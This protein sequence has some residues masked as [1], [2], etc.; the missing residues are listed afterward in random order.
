MKQLNAN[1]IQM[2]S[3]GDGTATVSGILTGVAAGALVIGTAGGVLVA[4]GLGG[5]I[6]QAGYMILNDEL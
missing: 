2:V 5:L 3:G 4:A 6:W 1:E